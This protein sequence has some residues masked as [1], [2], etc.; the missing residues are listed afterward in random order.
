MSFEWTLL[1][2]CAS[3]VAALALLSALPAWRMR[4][5]FSSP[6]LLLLIALVAAWALC[7]GLEVASIALPAK[8]WW[9]KAQWVSLV[10][11]PVC[12]LALAASGTGQSALVFGRYR[13]VLWIALPLCLMF[14]GWSNERHHLVWLNTVLPFDAAAQL[15]RLERGVF[16]WLNAF[17]AVGVNVLVL[18]LSAASVVR[19]PI[20]RRRYVIAVGAGVALPLCGNLLYVAGLDFALP[21]SY[22]VSGFLLSWGLYQIRQINLVPI[23]RSVIVEQLPDGVLVLD[24]DDRVIDCNPAAQRI[25]GVGADITGR[26]A[27]D[28]LR[29]LPQLTERY[30]D[31]LVANDLITLRDRMCELRISPLTDRLGRFAGRLIVVRDV[32][33][34][35]QAEQEVVRQK[36]LLENLIKV[37]RATSEQPML[38][39]TLQNVLNSGVELTQAD[40]GSLLLLDTQG[41]VI[42][43]LSVHETAPPWERRAFIDR[44]LRDGL[45][46]WVMRERRSALVLDTEQDS[47]W[48]AVPTSVPVRSALAV[49]ILNKQI[50]LGVLILT[51]AQPGHFTSDHVQVMESA[52][53]HMALAMRNARLYEAQRRMVQRQTALYEVLRALSAQFD[54]DGIAVTAVEAIGHFTTWPHIALLLADPDRQSWI[55][56]AISGQPSLALGA[57]L[58]LA[59]DATQPNPLAALSSTTESQPGLAQL[60]VSLWH[61]GTSIGLLLIEAEA[62]ARFDQEDHSLAQS[63]ADVI[64]LALH[65]AQLYQYVDDER[66]RLQASIRFNRDGIILLGMDLRILVINAPALRLLALSGEPEQWLN[67]SLQQVLTLLRSRRRQAVVR[68]AIHEMRRL[69]RDEQMPAEGDYEVAGRMLHWTSLPVL[70]NAQPIGRLIVLRD[71]TAEHQLNILREDLTSTLVHDLRNPI[72][73]VMGALELLDAEDLPAYQSEITRVA[74]QGAQRLLDL[75]NAILDVNRLESGQ[76]QLEREPLDLALAVREVIALQQILANNKQQT[77]DVHLPPDLPTLQVD[78]DLIRRV[79]QN[80]IGN[81]IKFTPSDGRIQISAW[82]I[83]E[84]TP[85][86]VVSVKDNGHGLSPDLQARL[87]QKFVTGRVHGRGSGLGLIFCRLAVE[88]HGG[89]IWLE[90]SD[91][92]GAD[93]RFALPLDEV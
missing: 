16:F 14:L 53:D 63:L 10:F 80:L 79:L 9:L 87:F 31:Q 22:W 68:A 20:F 51:H 21:I 30:G 13:W 73:V 4:A 55:V 39:D 89:R 35:K 56:R 78:Q 3:L 32:T 5:T 81:A 1:S 44:I 90:P 82:Q 24:K 91:D 28:V 34:R 2:L 43:A 60:T 46:G 54:V 19:Q 88:A 45:P 15:V 23:A 37:A 6:W 67:E 49:P 33:E 93:F 12:W 72:A 84:P 36:E 40:R 41:E 85:Q 47:R 17:Y 38:E 66:S 57:S 7:F 52:A 74:R 70:S 75:V 83:A 59:T 26:P 86:I 71:V 48:L 8:V 65:N 92:P 58:P 42:Q 11:L 64:A 62:A 69:Q 18:A 29:D 61:G 76:V 25:L 50:L 27:L 77:L